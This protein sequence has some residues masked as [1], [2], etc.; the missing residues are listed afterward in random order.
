MEF[1]NSKIKQ[2]LIFL[3][4]ELSSLKFKKILLYFRRE[5]VKSEKQKFLIFWEMKLSSRK[6][7]KVT[8]KA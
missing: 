4:M 7:K 6:I 3:E 5:F 2:F 1:S 8:C